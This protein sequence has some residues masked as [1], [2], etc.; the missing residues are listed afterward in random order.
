[1][2]NRRSSTVLGILALGSLFGLAGCPTVDLGDSPSD[3]GLCNPPGGAQYFQDSIWPDF[4]RPTNMT[5][6]CVKGGMCHSE[7]GGNILSFKTSPVDFAFNYR[8]TQIY[9]NCGSPMAS[10]LLTKPLAGVDPHGGLDIFQPGDPAVQ[11]FLDWF[12]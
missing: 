2:G 3:I 7:S 10:Q 6:G 5:N 8:A 12:M 9:L 1:M 4:V 11:V